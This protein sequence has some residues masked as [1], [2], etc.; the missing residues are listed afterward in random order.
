MCPYRK[1]LSLTGKLIYLLQWRLTP[2]SGRHALL[3]L[4]ICGVA[5]QTL[6]LVWKLLVSHRKPLHG[7][8]ARQPK[9]IIADKATHAKSHECNQ[10]IEMNHY[11]FICRR[12][13]GTTRKAI[14]EISRVWFVIKLIQENGWGRRTF[15][16]QPKC[17]VRVVGMYASWQEHSEG[18]QSFLLL[19]GKCCTQKGTFFFV[20]PR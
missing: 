2:H 3:R 16:Y 8:W 6:W 1:V 12:T 20:H 11:R 14:R 9:S 17:H 18:N 5:R 4:L 19:Q 15:T 13:C 10:P 7:L